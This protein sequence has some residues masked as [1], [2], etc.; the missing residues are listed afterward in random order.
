[1]PSVEELLKAYEEGNKSSS[2][3]SFTY[4]E[5]RYF[6]TWIPKD[7]KSNVTKKIRILPNLDGSGF[8]DVYYGHKGKVVG[9][10]NAQTFACLKK[11]G[12]EDSCPFCEMNAHL[13]KSTDPDK[14]EMAKEYYSRK[15]YILR[16]IDRNHED[17]GIK[18][19]RINHSSKNDGVMDKI[20]SIIKNK[21]EDISDLE[22][23]RDISIEIALDHKKNPTVVAILPEDKSRALENISDLEDMEGYTKTWKDIYSVKSYDYL[24]LVVKGEK[25]V[26]DKELNTFVAKQEESSVVDNDD[27]D[28]E[29]LTIGSK[30]SKEEL[31]SLTVSSTDEEDDDDDDV[32]F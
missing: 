18:F 16:V 31:N 8:Y 24:A 19:W 30:D 9:S 28:D 6:S 22:D 13:S 20:M 15:M 2:S 32:P 25:P 26:W 27:D 12:I 5:K 11:N 4:D 7:S 14:K 29:D 1:M 21:K 10:D 3:S 23:G 17:E